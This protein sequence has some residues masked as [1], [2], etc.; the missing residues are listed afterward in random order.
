LTRAYT[1]I[2][3]ALNS[4]HHIYVLTVTGDPRMYVSMKIQYFDKP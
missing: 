2:K 3:T 1:D 4:C